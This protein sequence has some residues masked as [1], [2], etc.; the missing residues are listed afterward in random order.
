MHPTWTQQVCGTWIVF[1]LCQCGRCDRQAAQVEETGQSSLEPQCW[2]LRALLLCRREPPTAHMGEPTRGR[3]RRGRWCPPPVC[4]HLSHAGASSASGMKPAAS[5]LHAGHHPMR[6]GLCEG[7]KDRENSHWSQGPKNYM[8][9][10]HMESHPPN[11]S[12]PPTRTVYA[13]TQQSQ[14][15]PCPPAPPCGQ[16]V[17][18]GTASLSE[19]SYSR[20]GHSSSASPPM[21]CVEGAFKKKKY[22]KHG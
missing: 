18:T 3:L 19:C 7:P 17:V 22:K 14:L 15:S 16:T 11:F 13:H 2:G 1:T 20:D 4:L 21:K 6:R 12:R 5:H 9:L 8:V 10:C